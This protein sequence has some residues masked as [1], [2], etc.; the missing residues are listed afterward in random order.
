VIVMRLWSKAFADEEPIPIE[1]ANERIRLLAIDEPLQADA[2]LDRW[3]LERAISGRYSNRELTQYQET[4]YAA[5]TARQSGG[6][7]KAQPLGDAPEELRKAELVELLRRIANTV[8]RQVSV[9]PA[10]LRRVLK[11]RDISAASP[12][13][14]R[15]ARR[16]S[17]RIPTM[18]PEDLHHR[19][20]PL[21][22]A[23]GKAELDQKLDR[24]N[25]LLGSRDQKATIRPT[26]IVTAA[27]HGRVD[28]LF[29][30]G[31]TSG[32]ALIKQK[33][34]SWCMTPLL[35]TTSTCSITRR[36]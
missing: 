11:S 19:A 18:R 31:A 10:P 15:C 26:E 22:A 21:A 34:G 6:L 1:Y 17:A 30:A 36:L 7:P 2:G 4:H 24:L 27:V 32:A 16:G 33:T 5:P 28:A 13:C 20:Y 3:A 29:V 14:R 23:I 9:D 12:L 25:A 35:P 8:E